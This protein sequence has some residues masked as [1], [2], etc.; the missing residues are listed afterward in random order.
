[1]VMEFARQVRLAH[2]HP[3]PDV[4]QP[5]FELLDPLPPVQQPVMAAEMLKAMERS[6][7]AHREETRELVE[8]RM[9]QFGRRIEGELRT[10]GEHLTCAEV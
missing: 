9:A 3:Q 7:R 6:L 8:D 2:P 1:M 5:E 10:M 4:L